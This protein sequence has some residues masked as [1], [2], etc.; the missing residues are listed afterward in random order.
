[1]SGVS[2]TVTVEVAAGDVPS[3]LKD[4]TPNVDDTPLVRPVNV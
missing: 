1:V 4:A 3:A 2:I